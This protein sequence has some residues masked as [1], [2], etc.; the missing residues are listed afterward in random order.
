MN[1][2]NFQKLGHKI[3]ELRVKQKL[4]QDELAEKAGIHNKYQGKIERAEKRP[5]IETLFKLAKALNV[6]VSEFFDFE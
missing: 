1:K 6:K 3:K 4:T 5:S 2:L